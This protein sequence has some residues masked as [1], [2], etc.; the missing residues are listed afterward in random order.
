MWL[1]QDPAHLYYPPLICIVSLAR[2]LDNIP[3]EVI[4]GVDIPTGVPLLYEFDEDMKPVV[5]E[6]HA[7]GLSGR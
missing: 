3:D 6:G 7:E 4:T 2:H 5:Q 1:V